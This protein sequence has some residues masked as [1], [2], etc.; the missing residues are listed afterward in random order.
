M[1]FAEALTKARISKRMNKTQVANYFGWTPMYYA[2]YENGQLLPTKVN[3]KKFADF[4]GISVDELI[5]L[6]EK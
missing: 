2:R 3:Y 5:E 4:I 6:I 1:E